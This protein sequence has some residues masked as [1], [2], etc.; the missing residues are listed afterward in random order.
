M[1]STV[2]AFLLYSLLFCIDEL[3]CYCC[4]DFSIHSLT[5]SLSTCVTVS[6]SPV[7]QHMDEPALVNGQTSDDTDTA[8]PQSKESFPSDSKSSSSEDGNTPKEQSISLS[9]P[10][11]QPWIQVEKRHRNSPGKN[12]VL[13]DPFRV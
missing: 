1:C 13:P 3:F 6:S 7:S 5:L 9:D 12:K 4:P 10:D 11:A 8:K 2:L